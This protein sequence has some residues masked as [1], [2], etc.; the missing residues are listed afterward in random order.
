M[1]YPRRM[2]Y[3]DGSKM[4]PVMT[5]RCVKMALSDA[6]GRFQYN[7]ILPTPFAFARW[8]LPCHFSAV[9]ATNG[10]TIRTRNTGVTENSDLNLGWFLLDS[11]PFYYHHPGVNHALVAL[12]AH[13][14]LH[15]R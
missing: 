15:T 4:D 14:A 11:W 1:R 13:L 9:A 2:R 8:G 3:R 12:G 6:F 10:S 7:R 5:D